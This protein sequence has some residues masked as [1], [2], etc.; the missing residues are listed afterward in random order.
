MKNATQLLNE[1]FQQNR[2]GVI[3]WVTSVTG[4]S[5]RPLVFASFEVNGKKYEGEGRS[6]KAA[7]LAAAENFFAGDEKTPLSLSQEEENLIEE[8][9][10]IFNTPSSHEFGGN[11]K[12][13]LMQLCKGSNTKEMIS[14]LQYM[15]YSEF[16]TEASEENRVPYPVRMGFLEDNSYTEKKIHFYDPKPPKTHF[17]AT[18]TP[19]GHQL[20]KK[21][22][23]QQR[24]K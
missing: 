10:N 14:E 22:S 6:V 24:G 2:W 4:P 5:H 16:P 1:A 15:E 21:L 11:I 18:V 3:N 13:Q 23:E 9:V 19:L 8:A 17:L 12:V 7:K 20:I